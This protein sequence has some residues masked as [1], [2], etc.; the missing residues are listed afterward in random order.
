VHKTVSS[1]IIYTIFYLNQ[2]TFSSRCISGVY[3]Q[4]THNNIVNNNF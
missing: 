3:K 1:V 2:I 4:I